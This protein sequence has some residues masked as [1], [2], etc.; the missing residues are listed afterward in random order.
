MMTGHLIPVPWGM[1]YGTP[2]LALDFTG[3][4]PSPDEARRQVHA[5]MQGRPGLTI[6]WIRQAPWESEEFASLLDVAL[7]VMPS[8][9]ATQPFNA[10]HWGFREVHWFT[11]CSGLL[12]K[13]TTAD[14]IA[15]RVA[16]LPGF[17]HPAELLVLTPAVENLNAGILDAVAMS[18][19]GPATFCDL[20]V[21]PDQLHRALQVVSRSCGGWH[22]RAARH[23]GELPEI[24]LFEVE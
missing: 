24:K 22:T 17:P 10:R 19:G 4:L 11:D 2:A 21:Y 1:A 8:V 6:A 3:D 7:D 23:R 9:Y 14:E 12:A 15:A 20:A 5:A 18:V 13:P 16:D